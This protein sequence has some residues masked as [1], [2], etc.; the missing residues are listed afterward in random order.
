MPH[1]AHGSTAQLCWA[2]CQQSWHVLRVSNTTWAEGY[3]LSSRNTKVVGSSPTVSTEFKDKFERIKDKTVRTATFILSYG[4]VVQQE[5][6]GV[7]SRRYGCKSHPI[8]WSKGLD[9]L[10]EGTTFESNVRC[11][12]A[13]F[14]ST[15]TQMQ[16]AFSQNLPL[17]FL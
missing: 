7:A 14:S 12:F 4:L 6:T 8:H 16:M 13:V 1:L 11:K 3:W 2:R 10:I 17:T 5:D 15:V 9:C